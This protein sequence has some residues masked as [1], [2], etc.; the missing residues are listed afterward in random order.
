MRIVQASGV[1]VLLKQNK[2]SNDRILRATRPLTIP[3]PPSWDGGFAFQ[4]AVFL[5]DVQL[6]R[7]RQTPK[8]WLF[9]AQQFIS[10]F[11]GVVDVTQRFD[12]DTRI[13]RD[14][15]SLRIVIGEIGD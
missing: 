2:Q 6:V 10:E 12:D 4:H 1:R 14:R 7:S 8:P 5:T 3:P 13:N 15:A 9:F 11:T